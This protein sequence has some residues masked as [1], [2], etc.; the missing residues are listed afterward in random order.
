MLEP[1]INILCT[2]PI[3][4]AAIREARSNGIQLDVLPFIDTEPVQTIEV[5][6]EIE[7]AAVELATVIFTSMN[8]V[9][10]V[11]RMLNGHVPD[12]KI[13]CLGHKTRELVE[14]SFGNTSISGIADNATELADEII[15]NGHTD[16]VIF[17]CGN[18]RRNELP[19]KLEQHGINVTEVIVYQTFHLHCKVEK[20]YDGVLFFSPS[21]VE[22]FFAGNHLPAKTVVFTIG[23]TT[24][25]AVGRYCSNR[26]IISTFPG[27][28]RMV[29]EAISY[30]K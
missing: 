25:E 10:S 1:E 16:E 26:C 29:K 5:Q 28:D 8:A 7:L 11:T 12:W 15:E 13:Y 22:S 30:F 17:F 21:A 9:E 2:R 6:Q 24:N 19:H 27:K 4:P 3:A 20:S 18:L 14:A 23:N